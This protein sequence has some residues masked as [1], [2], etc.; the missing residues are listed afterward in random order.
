MTNSPSAIP[1]TPLETNEEYEVIYRT[2]HDRAFDGLDVSVA[3]ALEE[4]IGADAVQII[5]GFSTYADP[6]PLNRLFQGDSNDDCTG[7]VN[8]AMEGYRVLIR[9][10]GEIV[11]YR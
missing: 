8:L 9:R 2:T 5:A 11:I 6:D 1:D 3:L 10:N 7:M 4:A